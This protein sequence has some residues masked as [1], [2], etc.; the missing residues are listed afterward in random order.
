MS[1]CGGAYLVPTTFFSDKYSKGNFREP[2]FWEKE[3]SSW[4][5]VVAAFPLEIHRGSKR[6]SSVIKVTRDGLMAAEVSPQARTDD[7]AHDIMV[8]HLSSFLGLL[9]LGGLNF[10]SPST[11]LAHVGVDDGGLNLSGVCGDDFNPPDFKRSLYRYQTPFRPGTSLVDFDWPTMRIVPPAELLAAER[12]GREIVAGFGSQTDL[13]VLA[14]ESF[15][16][17][18]LGKVKE[19][20]LLGWAFVEF[21]LASLWEKHIL[22]STK[23]QRKDRLEDHRTYT[24]AVRIEVLFQTKVLD[25]KLYDTL[26]T[27]RKARND[28]IHKGLA[29][30]LEDAKQVFCVTSELLRLAT[31]LHMKVPSLSMTR[32]CCWVEKAARS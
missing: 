25:E 9:Y 2:A 6:H 5:E 27:L 26:N 19:S 4:G 18:R 7:E 8:A 32:S 11:P 30:G 28:L 20:L 10:L 14:F 16:C 15:G 17:Y 13:H 21:L 23:G 31:G 24:A 12:T 22:Y 3:R 1:K 29:C